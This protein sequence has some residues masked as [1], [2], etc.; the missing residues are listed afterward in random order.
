MPAAG[1][2]VIFDRSW[3]NRPG[4][5][6]VMGFCS[7]S[8]GASLS[9]FWLRCFEAAIVESGITLLKYFLECERRRTGEA[10]SPA[11]R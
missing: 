4:V 1:E 5:E 6:R 10:F 3:Y 9:S 11:H 7:G 8:K 2:I